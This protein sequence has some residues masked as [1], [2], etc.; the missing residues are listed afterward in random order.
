MA[1][2]IGEHVSITTTENSAG[3]SFAGFGTQA[4]ASC[5]ATFPERSRSYSDLPEMASDGMT[6]KTPEYR[7]AQKAF[8]Q[9]PRPKTVKIIKMLG[10][11][12][13]KYKIDI[14]SVANSRAYT[15]K[16]KGS[17]IADTTCTFTSDGT[18]LN[19]EITAG[20]L[21]LIN[22]IAS[23][24]FTCTE[25]GSALSKD[26]EITGNAPGDWFSVEV[27][28]VSSLTVECTHAEPATTIAA[29]LDAVQNADSD[30]Y[31]LTYLYPSDAC[32]KAVA[33]WVEDKTKLYIQHM[34]DSTLVTGGDATGD[35]CSDLKALNYA[36][37]AI[38][39]H[40]DPASFVASAWMGRVLSTEPG[41]AT[42]KAKVLK[43]VVSSALS[44]TQRTN[45]R[46]KNLNCYTT[47][48]VRGW[49][50]EGKTVDG[51][52]IDVTRNIDW[53]DDRLEKRIANAIETND[54]IPMSDEGIQII[55]AEMEATFDE[56][57]D[58]KIFLGGDDAPVL[59]VPRAADISEN[60]RANRLLPDMNWSA[61]LA[62]AVHKV[63]VFGNV[64]R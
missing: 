18:A 7:A 61:K 9:K 60:D 34:S 62:G 5:N 57:V 32:V 16:L 37:T 41:K 21:A 26:L 33:A 44:T 12:T 31:G 3:I 51:D 35:T 20:L 42:W 64:A 49:T 38:I 46:A 17:T 50:W 45:A 2:E 54:I 24:N 4:I 30:W 59:S 55:R 11:P 22:A 23:K 63:D 36:R 25:V 19:D 48:G 15:V 52:F 53:V 8:G 43:G 29:D 47:V 13:L 10:K 27:A 1:S 56:A 14:A 6:S 39:Y 58:R 28:D 40:P